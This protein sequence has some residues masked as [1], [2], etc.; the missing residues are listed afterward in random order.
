MAKVGIRDL[1]YA[2]YASGGAGSAVTYTGGVM[3]KDYMCRGE[4]TVERSGVK[5]HADDH[6]IDIDNTP[7]GVTLALELAN[8]DADMKGPFCGLVAGS[9]AGEY[10]L[11][12]D[13]APYIG[14]GYI[15]VNRFK[16]VITYEAVWVYKIQFHQD[17]TA[18]D[19]K[20]EQTSFQ[21]E[22]V[23]GDGVGVQL[24]EGGK[25]YYY[26]NYVAETLSAAETWLKGK[27]GAS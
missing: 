15:M 26:D 20:G 3:K 5:E 4:L 12:E 18:V 8:L 17:S 21:H 27:A 14:C 9:T 16:K 25:I 2:T 10:S 11:T 7:T 19:T 24:S 22:N 6:Q 13:D 23:T 1:T